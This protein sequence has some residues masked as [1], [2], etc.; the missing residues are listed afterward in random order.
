MDGFS[1]TSWGPVGASW[2]PPG[3]VF[4]PSGGYPG[5]EGPKCRVG[6]CRGAFLGAV[7]RVS[8]AVLGV[9]CTVLG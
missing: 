8:G 3:A 6:S 5:A 1:R 9:S 4:E 2:G 7:L